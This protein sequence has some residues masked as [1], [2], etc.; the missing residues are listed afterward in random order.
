[1]KKNLGMLRIA[2]PRKIARM[3]TLLDILLR[4]NQKMKEVH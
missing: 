3:S 4:E 2:K 1:M